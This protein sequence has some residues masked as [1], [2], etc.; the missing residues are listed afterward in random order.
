MGFRIG[1]WAVNGQGAKPPPPL[2][3]S[4]YPTPFIPPPPPE[5]QLLNT[6]AVALNNLINNKNTLFSLIAPFV[7]RLEVHRDKACVLK[8]SVCKHHINIAQEFR[9]KKYYV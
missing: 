3:L 1:G 6:C 7:Q 8:C 9:G 5:V 4:F 2:T